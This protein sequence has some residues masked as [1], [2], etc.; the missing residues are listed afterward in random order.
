[1]AVHDRTRLTGRLPFDSGTAVHGKDAKN[2]KL[3]CVFVKALLCV[4]CVS[5]VK[6]VFMDEHWIEKMRI[7]PA[8]KHPAFTA[9]GVGVFPC[10]SVCFRG[11][12]DFAGGDNL[13]GNRL[14][15][16]VY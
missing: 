6:T 10:Y 12:S 2:A 5:A 11:H 4:L 14:V 15:N 16:K 9:Y 3:L 1:M 13:H 8:C 7:H